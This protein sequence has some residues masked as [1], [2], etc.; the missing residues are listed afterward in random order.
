MDDAHDGPNDPHGAE[1]D[2]G[3]LGDGPDASRPGLPNRERAGRRASSKSP[4]R[5]AEE[6]E[7]AGEARERAGQTDRK[8]AD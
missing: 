5:K 8:S 3:E 1:R 2:P 4:R 6:S 7:A